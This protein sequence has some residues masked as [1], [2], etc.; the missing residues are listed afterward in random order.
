LLFGLA[1]W[2]KYHRMLLLAGAF[3]CGYWLATTAPGLWDYLTN[4][5]GYTILQGMSDERPYIELSREFGG[6]LVGMGA[7]FFLWRQDKKTRSLQK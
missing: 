3:F 6:A 7:L 4:Q 2:N 5:E 1:L